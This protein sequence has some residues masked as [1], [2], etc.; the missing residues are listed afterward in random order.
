V[1]LD[2]YGAGG[3]LIRTLDEGTENAGLHSIVWDATGL[4]SGVYFYRLSVGKQTITKKCVV[5]NP[6]TGR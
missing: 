4:S 5:M 6:R 2:V 3:R 1:R